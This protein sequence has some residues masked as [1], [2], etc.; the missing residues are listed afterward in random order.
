V[1]GWW[2]DMAKELD[3]VLSRFENVAEPISTREL[4][5]RWKE[6]R[7]E[8]G[9]KGLDFLVVQGT[10]RYMGGYVRWFTDFAPELYPVTVLFPIEG[11]IILI[12]SMPLPR[13]MLGG[14][15]KQILVPQPMFPLAHAEKVVEVL[16]AKKPSKVGLVDL[17]M[18]AYGG[19]LRYSHKE[20][21]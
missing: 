7:R 19:N 14:S 12:Y 2:V 6:V 18:G 16:K 1:G 9:N 3:D 4:E 21:S 13:W 20:T 11:E 15:I 8:M 5:R 10:Y 17:G